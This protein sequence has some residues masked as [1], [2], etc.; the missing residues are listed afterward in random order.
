MYCKIS[1]N[2]QMDVSRCNAERLYFINDNK[3]EN[4]RKM[5]GN[6]RKN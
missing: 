4:C 3:R 6:Q 1:G 2:L 5:E